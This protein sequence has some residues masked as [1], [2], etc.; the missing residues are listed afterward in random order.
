[1]TLHRGFLADY[2][3]KGERKIIFSSEY[4]KPED[5]PI[6]QNFS[7]T[8]PLVSY[9]IIQFLD[10]LYQLVS[11]NIAY[12]HFYSHSSFLVSSFSSTTHPYLIQWRIL[13][14]RASPF[15]SASLRKF[16]SPRIKKA[17]LSGSVLNDTFRN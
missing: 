14:S 11:Q 8:H 4:K 1:M 10:R 3:E 5:F 7:S 6:K 12:L 13:P 2:V 17:I 15:L 16:P 9:K